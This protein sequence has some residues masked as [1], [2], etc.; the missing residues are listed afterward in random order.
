[1]FCHG[2]TTEHVEKKTL[3][4][5][6]HLKQN[7]IKNKELVYSIGCMVTFPFQVVR[8]RLLLMN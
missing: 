4:Q 8:N 7:D 1:M 2:S 6:S 5:F 3:Y